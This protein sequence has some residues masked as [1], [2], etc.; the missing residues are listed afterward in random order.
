MKGSV[1][2][3][4]TWVQHVRPPV[5]CIQASH[6]GPQTTH[7]SR[8]RQVAEAKRERSL[9]VTHHTLQCQCYDQNYLLPNLASWLRVGML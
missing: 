9:E 7:T 2:N 4:Q 6:Q 5:E 1:D 3:C 8:Y